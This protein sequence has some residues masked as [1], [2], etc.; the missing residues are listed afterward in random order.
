M[1]GSTKMHGDVVP[2]KKQGVNNQNQKNK[3]GSV[4]PTKS[5]E[6]AL[7]GWKLK[8]LLGTFLQAGHGIGLT[9][10]RSTGMVY[11]GGRTWGIWDGSKP[12]SFPMHGGIHIYYQLFWCEGP[13]WE[14][15]FDPCRHPPELWDPAI[16]TKRCCMNCMGEACSMS[17]F[18]SFLSWHWRVRSASAA[19]SFLIL[20]LSCWQFPHKDWKLMSFSVFHNSGHLWTLQWSSPVSA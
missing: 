18:W 9:L 12:M 15:A 10:L 3:W 20:V 5:V 1:A 7:N 2:I 17:E 13:I 6:S 4:S 11:W 14:P 8:S 19:L 16:M